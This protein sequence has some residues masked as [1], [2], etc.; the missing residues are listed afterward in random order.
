M[1]KL[2]HSR[3]PLFYYI[4]SRNNN[5]NPKAHGDSCKRQTNFC[6]NI[7][8]IFF[9]KGKNTVDN[10]RNRCHDAAKSKSRGIHGCIPHVLI[11]QSH[12]NRSK[13][14]CG[15]DQPKRNKT[16]FR[17]RFSNI[18]YFISYSFHSSYSTL[19][20][21]QQMPSSR[22]RHQLYLTADHPHRNFLL[23]LSTV[24]SQFPG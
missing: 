7:I 12:C 24:R 11:G 22:L 9:S 14:I 18:R 19:L 10:G 20:L 8:L 2:I 15:Y 5:H 4:L 6:Q 21:P 23:E 17:Q 16:I 13:Y 1:S 3:K